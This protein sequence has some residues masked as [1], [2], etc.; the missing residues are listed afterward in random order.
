MILDRFYKPNDDEVIYHYCPP[1]AFVEII[2]T[3]KIWHSAYYSLNDLSERRWAY[4]VFDKA[5]AQIQADVEKT[6][7]DTIR[8]FVNMALRSSLIMISSY[9]LDPDVLSQWRAYAEDGKG[10]AIGF[11]ARRME[12]PAKSIRVL[13]DE[14][15]QNTELLGNLRHIYGYERS[16][17]FK[18]DMQFQTHVFNV[19]LDLCAY[20]H[21]SFSAEKEIRRAHV[22]GL[23]P[24]GNSIKIIPLGALDQDGKRLS[25]P[26]DVQFRTKNSVLVPYVTLDYTNRGKESPIK[27]IVLGPRNDNAE[28]N[29]Q[30]F[31][32]T[33]G[34]KDVSVRRSAVPYA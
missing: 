18:Y 25:E 13:Y 34:M 14:E 3:R 22:S 11:I 4:S 9:S 33:M 32:N 20:K 31:I 2:R 17:G 19:G 12:M 6:F 23:A 27:E 30:L 7:T 16:I 26:V 1:S 10:F 28:L 15:A 21:P 24:D 8:D 29:I 5:L